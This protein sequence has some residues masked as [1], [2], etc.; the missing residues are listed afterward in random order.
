MQVIYSK[1]SGTVCM[2]F[3]ANHRAFNKLGVYSFHSHK[4]DEERISYMDTTK[5]ILL[6]YLKA[7]VVN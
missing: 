2:K 5:E 7:I 1:I 3:L 4:Y 6:Q